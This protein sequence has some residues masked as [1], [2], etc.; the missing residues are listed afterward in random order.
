M[1]ID[2]GVDGAGCDAL[3]R[4]RRGNG[5]LPAVE[6]EQPLTVAEGDPGFVENALRQGVCQ[7]DG[8]KVGGWMRRLPS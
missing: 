3:I 6:A 7:F 8:A 4:F 2:A 1:R 5:R